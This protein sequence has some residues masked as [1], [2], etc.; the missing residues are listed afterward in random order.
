[1]LHL[2]VVP[3]SLSARASLT[4]ILTYSVPS[5]F[6]AHCFGSSGPHTPHLSVPHPVSLTVLTVLSSCLYLLRL[7]RAM[8]RLYCKSY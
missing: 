5:S 8:Q 6:P 1:M 7:P 2:D 3:P 4:C